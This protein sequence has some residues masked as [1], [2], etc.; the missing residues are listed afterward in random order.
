MEHGRELEL[1]Q[2]EEMIEDAIGLGLEQDG[3]KLSARREVVAGME[4]LILPDGTTITPST[5]AMVR[6][7]ETTKNSERHV[8]ISFFDDHGNIG[9]CITVYNKPDETLKLATEA[10][11]AA[12]KRASARLPSTELATTMME[13]SRYAPKLGTP[14][15]EYYQTARAMIAGPTR[16]GHRP[17][18]WP[19]VACLAIFAL[20]PI[21]LAVALI[22]AQ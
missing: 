20:G 13:I 2:R 1:R 6:L 14:S 8:Q 9:S 21:A 5:I 19:V 17:I 15:M 16:P 10:H 11:L 22:A 12:G 18:T 4:T 7:N 3:G